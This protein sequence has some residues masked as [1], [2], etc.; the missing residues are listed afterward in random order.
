MDVQPARTMRNLPD[1]L[2]SLMGFNK[3]LT[4][5]W[6][7]SVSHIIDG[8]S[9][10]KPQMKVMVEKDENISDDNT[11]SEAKVQKIQD[12]LVS[13][14]AQL[15]QITLQRREALNNYLD[16]K[17]NIRVFCRIRPFHHEESYS[18]RNLFTLDESNVFLKVAETKRKQYKFDKVFDQ[19]S[20]QGDVFSEVE[21][22][23]KSALD[24]YNVC[25]FAYGQTGSGKTY[26]MS[27]T[28]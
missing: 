25:I 2:S 27:I 11:E 15:K 8:L 9:P 22:V 3:H 7:E 21:P 12:E 28:I 10:T 18:S 19:F 20:T 14:N 24:G 26:T 1:T 5:S 23:I 4:P 17:G 13:L 16:L 6:I